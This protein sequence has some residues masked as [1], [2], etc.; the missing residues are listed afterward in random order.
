LMEDDFA[1][2][3]VGIREGRTIFD[4]LA[5]TVAYTVTHT[6]PELA[7][8]VLTLCS[9]IPLSMSPIQT[10]FIDLCTEMA[11]AISFAYE[12]A[13]ADVMARPPRNAKTER[14]VS[15]R[16]I[17]FCFF[18]AGAI[19]SLVGFLAFFLVFNYYGIPPS[20]L[21]NSANDY[22]QP[23]GNPPFVVG[24]TSFYNDR[25]VEIL[26]E[27]QT[28]YWLMI[29][30][31]QGFHVWMCKTRKRSIFE[32]GLFTNDF[33]LLGSLT[34]WCFILLIIYLPFTQ[35]SFFQTGNF[36]GQF[37]PVILVA[38]TGLFLLHEVRKWWVRNHPRGFV[39]RWL[40]W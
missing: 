34:Q 26:S 16:M 22:F 31:G 32:V 11:P 19:E 35:K 24:S 2:I 18:Q 13:E 8:V 40:S 4:N 28:A 38:W 14:L 39:D 3:V 20:A 21:V 1:S 17:L 15:L 5:K 27:A 7:P 6:I 30:G 33:M 10:L 12:P 23:C 29:T 9:S 37:W 36:P 25:Q